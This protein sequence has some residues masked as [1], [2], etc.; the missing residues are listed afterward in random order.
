MLRVLP[1]LLAAAMPGTADAAPVLDARL[2][3]C[4]RQGA[5]FVGSM[6]ALA[7]T[8]RMEMRFDL[9]AREAGEP[10]RPVPAPRFGGWERSKP[11]RSGFV[12]EKR[13][14]RLDPQRA[15]RAVVRFRWLD[16]EGVVQR[17]ARRLTEVC[18]PRPAT[19]GRTRSVATM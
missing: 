9:E 19:A 7:G 2:E 11:R 17:R 16:A 6:P 1:L 12:Y 4:D 13:V 8:E 18:R 5:S 3:S 14:E 10:W 15:Y